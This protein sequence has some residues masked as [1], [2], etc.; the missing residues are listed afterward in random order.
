MNNFAKLI[1]A[2]AVVLLFTVPTL[3]MQNARAEEAEVA[4][5]VV[6][7]RVTDHSRYVI[8]TRFDLCFY[9]TTVPYG[10]SV[11]PL[12]EWQCEELKRKVDK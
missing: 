7:V 4:Q 10:V 9:E 5:G 8:D 12:E 1:I 6:Q 2:V 3:C 11:V